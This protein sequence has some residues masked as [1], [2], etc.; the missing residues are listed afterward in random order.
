MFN[1]LD[2]II[3]G[4]GL[5]G[6]VAAEKLASSGKKVLVIEKKNHIG[7]QCFDY[8]N[9]SGIYIHQYGPHIFHTDKENVWQY[10]SRFTSWNYYEHKVVG[11]IDGQKVPIPFN[12]NS[13]EKL[14][15]PYLYEKLEKK[16]IKEYG[17]NTRVPIM[18]LRAAEDED[19]LF[20]ANYIY[21]K[22][23]LNYTMKQW[24]RSKPEDIDS[25]V[26]GRVPVVIS[27]DDRYFHNKHQGLPVNGFSK[28]F[29][30][31]VESPNIHLLMNVDSKDVISFKDDSIYFGGNLFKGKL[32]YTGIIDELFNNKH[33][34]LPYRS[35]DIKIKE[36]NQQY[37]QDNSVVNY[38][39]NYDLTR[40]T[41]F[42]YFQRNCKDLPKTTTICE[43]H[44]ASYVKGENNPFYVVKSEESKKIHAE[45]MRMAANIKGLSF[46]GRLAEYKYYDMDSAVESALSLVSQL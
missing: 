20:L 37:F 5:S 12:L 25:S 28:M 22:V 3:V 8:L 21:E 24:G 36:Y 18:E 13:L 39:N 4:S 6:I 14:F 45:Y 32:I 9:E 42:K 33:G 23:F 17:Y 26:S 38:P 35:V 29:S 31:M 43:E 19:L 44:P 41:E 40:I 30:R 11:V 10:L 7:G 27:R 1:K 16:L 15:S 2:V 46:L 34:D